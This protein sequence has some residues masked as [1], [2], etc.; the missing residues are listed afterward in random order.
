MTEHRINLWCLTCDRAGKRHLSTSLEESITH[1]QTEHADVDVD[2]L[3]HDQIV[4]VFPHL[5]Q[6]PAQSA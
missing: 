2:Q 1:Y 4:T 6:T 3:A 5:L